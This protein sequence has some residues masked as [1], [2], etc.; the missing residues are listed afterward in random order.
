MVCEDPTS[1]VELDAASLWTAAVTVKVVMIGTG[2]AVFFLV[3]VFLKILFIAPCKKKRE[4]SPRC[5]NLRAKKKA[6]ERSGMS[7]EQL[8]KKKKGLNEQ[9]YKYLCRYR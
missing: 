4:L 5:Q 7:S 8:K 1:T 6:D 2:K 3:L 9:F